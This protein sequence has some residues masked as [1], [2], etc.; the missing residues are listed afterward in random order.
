MLAGLGGP[1]GGSEAGIK[2]TVSE[3]SSLSQVQAL[4]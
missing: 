2:G 4:L 3:A 1:T